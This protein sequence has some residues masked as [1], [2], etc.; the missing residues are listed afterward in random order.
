MEVLQELLTA[1][2]EYGSGTVSFGMLCY[3][4]YQYFKGNIKRNDSLV[5]SVDTLAEAVL[6]IKDLLERGDDAHTV[7]TELLTK[8][9]VKTDI[10]V[11]KHDS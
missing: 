5:K 6:L 11:N 10:I 2:K 7:H 9:D 1:I 3:F 4:F 8:I